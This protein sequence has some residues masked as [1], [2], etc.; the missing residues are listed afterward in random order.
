MDVV[1]HATKLPEIESISSA[2]C[3]TCSVDPSLFTLG[4]HAQRGYGSWVCLSVSHFSSVFSSHKGYDL[5]LTDTEG[6]KVCAVFSET[7]P[8]QS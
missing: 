5:H 4:A 2:L 8:L 7:A 1:D 3:A 6:Q